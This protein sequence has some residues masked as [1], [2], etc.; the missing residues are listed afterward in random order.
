VTDDAAAKYLAKTAPKPIT[1]IPNPLLP[2]FYLG[3]VVSKSDSTVSALKNRKG[4]HKMIVGLFP[5][6]FRTNDN[7]RL[8]KKP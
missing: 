3:I 8:K 4:T 1:A 5:A 6:A 2:K 7:T